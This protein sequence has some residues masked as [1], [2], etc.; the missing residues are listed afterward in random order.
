MQNK[1]SKGLYRLM[2]WLNTELERMKQLKVGC[3]KSRP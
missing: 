2:N 1:D 3:G